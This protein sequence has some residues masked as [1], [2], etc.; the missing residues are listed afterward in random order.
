MNMD[1]K[2]K[3][4]NADTILIDATMMNKTYI[5]LTRTINILWTVDNTWS[6]GLLNWPQTAL[7]LFT[8][9][10]RAK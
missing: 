6:E 1:Y 9:N 2:T 10:Q 7:I 4:S 8:A 3:D 5:L